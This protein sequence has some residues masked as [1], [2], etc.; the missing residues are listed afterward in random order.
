MQKSNVS[1]PNSKDGVSR[2]MK[3]YH[4]TCCII[5]SRSALVRRLLDFNLISV[6]PQFLAARCMQSG[7]CCLGYVILVVSAL[8]ELAGILKPT[9]FQCV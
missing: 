9:W 8:V 4:R 5:V 3:I 2:L 7:T 1:R 6:S